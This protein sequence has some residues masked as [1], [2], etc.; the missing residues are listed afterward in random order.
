MD[1]VD[2]RGARWWWRALQV[3]LVLWVLQ[4]PQVLGCSRFSNAF[5]STSTMVSILLTMASFSPLSWK[6]LYVVVRS[7]LIESHILRA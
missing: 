5:S 3:L 1:K 2:K 6:N 4:V 7:S